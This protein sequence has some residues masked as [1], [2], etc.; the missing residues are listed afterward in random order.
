MPT[1]RRILRAGDMYQLAAGRAFVF[2]LDHDQ[3]ELR[4]MSDVDRRDHV[5]VPLFD[6]IHHGA[7]VEANF[8]GRALWVE[9]LEVRA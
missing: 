5:T 1:E 3:V 2:A 4:P 8:A 6:L 7:L 9:P